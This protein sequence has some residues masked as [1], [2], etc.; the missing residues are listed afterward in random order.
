MRCKGIISVL[1]VGQWLWG[2]RCYSEPRYAG[3][4][5]PHWGLKVNPSLQSTYTALSIHPA[6]GA[7]IISVCAVRMSLWT[8]LL[9]S[10][11]PNWIV[12]LILKRASQPRPPLKQPGP[13]DVR[14]L[15][16][17]RIYC[18]GQF[19]DSCSGKA[20]CTDV[21]QL[22]HLADPKL[23]KYSHHPQL[24][25][26]PFDTYN[27]NV[28][29]DSALSI[30][31]KHY[32]S[33]NILVC[34]SLLLARCMAGWL[35]RGDFQC[36]Q[37]STTVSTAFLTPPLAVSVRSTNTPQGPHHRAAHE[38]GQVKQHWVEQALWSEAEE[39]DEIHRKSERRINT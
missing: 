19:W 23:Y 37:L 27:L 26:L 20:S 17:C 8:L 6:T 10:Q 2:N 7:I 33:Q 3:Y 30:S 28:G 4:L 11:E 21:G 39:Q 9:S 5:F 29:S 25:Y 15:L 34:Q 36:L 32:H 31:T 38:V 35:P 14:K 16:G 24:L 18:P 22:T 13:E 1:L 12:A